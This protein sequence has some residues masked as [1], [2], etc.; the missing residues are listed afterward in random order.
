[1]PFERRGQRTDEHLAVMKALWCDEVSEYHGELYDL[2]PCRGPAR[3]ARA[4]GS[5]PGCRGT[6]P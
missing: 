6:P 2:P 1:M 5:R 4:P 3:A